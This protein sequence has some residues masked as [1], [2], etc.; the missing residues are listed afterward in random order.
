MMF[1]LARA[2]NAPVVAILVNVL[3]RLIV[4]RTVAL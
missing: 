1:D 3:A 2:L 4:K